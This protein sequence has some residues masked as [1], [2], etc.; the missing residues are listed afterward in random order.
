MP[1]LPVTRAYDAHNKAL[2]KT[3]QCVA[4]R[5]MID[6]AKEVRQLKTEKDD[7]QDVHC[8]VSCDVTWQERGHSSL[9]GCVTAISMDTGKCL[10][11]KVMT[12]NCRGCK[13]IGG[14]ENT[15]E[16]QVWKVDHAGKCKQNFKGSAQEQSSQK[17]F[18]GI[19][20]A[21]R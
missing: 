6:A 8:G 20:K 5:S 13:I 14:K 7:D 15:P 10:D 18:A 3:V 4:K 19:K 16:Y 1:K 2:S 9:N 11:V 17:A 12:K 21:Q